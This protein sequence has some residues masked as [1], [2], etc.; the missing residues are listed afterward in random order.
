MKKRKLL[1]L[2]TLVGTS[3]AVLVGCTTAGD[4]HP[5]RVV[6]K[7]LNY[8]ESVLYVNT[9][10]YGENAVYQG[11]TPTR[12]SSETTVYTF[13]GWDKPLESIKEDTSFYAQYVESTRKY[14][15]QFVDYNDTLLEKQQLEYGSMPSYS[16][17]IPTRES[18]SQ[19]TYVFSHWTPTIETVKSDKVYKA[20]YSR[21]DILYTVTWN[22]DGNLSTEKYRYGESPSY[23][24]STSKAQTAQYSYV[25]AG[26]EPSLRDVTANITYTAK[27]N[28]TVN[29]Y[30]ITWNVDG[31]ITNETYEYGSTPS[32]KG[33]TDKSSTAQYTYTFSGWSPSIETVTGNQTYTAQYD[34]VVNRYTI[35]WNVDG[36]VTQEK[37]EYGAMP[38]FKGSTDKDPDAQ[39]SYTFTSW[40]PS[41]VAVTGDATYTAQYS[42]SINQYNVTWKNDDGSILKTEKYNYGA[43]PNYGSTPVSSDDYGYITTFTGWYPQI[44][45]VIEDIEYTAQYDKTPRKFYITVSVPRNGDSTHWGEVYLFSEE[46]DQ[47]T[48]VEVSYII[49]KLPTYF[50]DFDFSS[51]NHWVYHKFVKLYVSVSYYMGGYYHEYEPGEKIEI[52]GPMDLY[53][54]YITSECGQYP[55]SQINDGLRLDTIGCDQWWDINNTF[56]IPGKVNPS[57]DTGGFN[58]IV[59]LGSYAFYDGGLTG[60]KVVVGDGMLRLGDYSLNNGANITYLEL[61]ASITKIGNFAMYS[62]GNLTSIKY[63]GKKSQWNSITKGESWNSYT[64]TTIHCSDGDITL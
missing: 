49:N 53:A 16:K 31:K 23:K 24:G 3:L 44:S 61:P 9:I 63:N 15:I 51:L 36:A 29:K 1:T 12:A 38:S 11:E 19:Y 22:V 34:S 14:E 21:E 7:F 33:S 42:S 26:W 30:T 57:Y 27:Y 54:E 28:S 45:Q 13:S 8:D 55:T 2:L 41:I 60:L 56:Y 17:G 10:P 32:Y 64:I 18:D 6:T 50:T 62:C 39:Y 43:M 46:F 4:N 58:E 47:G 37:Y 25:F 52:N 35:S 48:E 59:E 40:S 5:S 20:V